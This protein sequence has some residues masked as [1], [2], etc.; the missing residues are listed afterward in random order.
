MLEYPLW[1]DRTLD[2][3]F[4]TAA[5]VFGYEYK[6]L[7]PRALCLT[8]DYSHTADAWLQSR[9]VPEGFDVL[10]AASRVRTVR[11]RVTVPRDKRAAMVEQILTYALS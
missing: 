5:R 3:W 11:R 8:G 6:P 10:E 1:Y 7:I 9:M 2:Y 4:T